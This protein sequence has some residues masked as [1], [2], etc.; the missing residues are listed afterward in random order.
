MPDAALCYMNDVYMMQHWIIQG[1][2]Y[3]TDDRETWS[4][5]KRMSPLTCIDSGGPFRELI[6]NTRRSRSPFWRVL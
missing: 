2:K 3:M 4:E 5:I 6:Q 1:D